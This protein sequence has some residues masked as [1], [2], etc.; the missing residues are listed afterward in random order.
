VSAGEVRHV[1]RVSGRHLSREVVPP[2]LLASL[3]ARKR[4]RQGARHA[5]T[6]GG[7][8]LRA[9]V[10]RENG[11]AVEGLESLKHVVDLEVRIAIDR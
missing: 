8:D 7:I 10:R 1:D 3:R 5:S 2:D 6:K 4:Q 11:H 9:E